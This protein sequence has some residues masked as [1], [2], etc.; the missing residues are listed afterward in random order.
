MGGAEDAGAARHRHS[1]DAAAVA[2]GHP[3]RGDLPVHSPHHPRLRRG[4]RL[5][6]PAPGPERHDERGRPREADPDL[7][8]RRAE[9][10]RA[11]QPV[12]LVQP[13]GPAGGRWTWT[14]R[15][16]ARSASRSTTCSP[17]C[18]PRWAAPTSTTSTGS[19]GST[20]STSR[21]S[22]RSVRS[23]RTSASSTSAARPRDEMI[24]LSTLMTVTPGSGH[25]DHRPVQPVPLGGD[26]RRAGARL[27]LRPGDD[28]ARGGRRPR[29]CRARW[30]SPTRASPTRRSRRRRRGR[31]SS[32]RSSSCSCSS[33]R[34]TR[35]G[36]C[37]GRCCWRPRWWRWAPSSAC[38]SRATTTTCSSR[39]V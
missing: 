10:A 25:R 9:A 27:H 13:A 1:A 15:R 39:S 17:P 19:A 18:R 2:R 34:C 35:A 31:P 22:R 24:P 29:C 12:H 11:G 26:Q 37:P 20:G 33:R 14:G 32:W 23:P 16:R 38:G 7:P 30:G 36:S 28:G 4:R 3:R 6:L 5:Q 8:R 21:R